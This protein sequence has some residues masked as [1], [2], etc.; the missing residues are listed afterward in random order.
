MFRIFE[1][2]LNKSITIDELVTEILKNSD[3]DTQI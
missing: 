1:N 2:K 3:V